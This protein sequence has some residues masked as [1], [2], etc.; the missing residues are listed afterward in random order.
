MA[1][2]FETEIIE[3]EL[4]E[5]SRN[6]LNNQALIE[7][8]SKHPIKEMNYE[9][10]RKTFQ[11]KTNL[12]LTKMLLGK[13]FQNHKDFEKIKDNLL[14]STFRT[15]YTDNASGIGGETYPH[16]DNIDFPGDKDSNLLITWGL[17]TQ[18]ATLK[19]TEF[20]TNTRDILLEEAKETKDFTKMDLFPYLLEGMFDN[21]VFF[22]DEPATGRHREELDRLLDLLIAK[23]LNKQ[24]KSLLDK[25]KEIVLRKYGEILGSISTKKFM[26]SKAPNDTENIS[27]IIISGK[28][29]Y[30]RRSPPKKD[31][32][33][34]WRYA[35]NIYFNRNDT[36]IDESPL[37]LGGRKTKKKSIKNKRVK[38]KKKTKRKKYNM[39][40]RSYV[41]IINIIT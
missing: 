5:E 38:K 35:L 3:I 10:F 20:L 30:H 14:I 16:T 9:T 2:S 28:Y 17:G 13:L 41:I 26:E 37:R 11:D 36:R 21:P 32:L 18:A 1:E 29:V 6:K 23:E 22:E 4:D 39:K 15:I 31:T 33:P 25:F 40:N 34:T 7:E 27:A 24:N 8:E 12:N 19:T